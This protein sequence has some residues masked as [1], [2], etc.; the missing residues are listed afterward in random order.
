M[1]AGQWTVS[2]MFFQH[3]RDG[4]LKKKQMLVKSETYIKILYKILVT[5][6]L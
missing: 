2:D 3:D 4:A 5:V 1:P 6:Y